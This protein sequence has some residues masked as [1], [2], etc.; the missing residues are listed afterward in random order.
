MDQPSP[1]QFACAWDAAVCPSTLPESYDRPT[2]GT[3]EE[4]AGGTVIGYARLAVAVLGGED[5][6]R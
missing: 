3:S 6:I 2:N 5:H 1:S 4:A